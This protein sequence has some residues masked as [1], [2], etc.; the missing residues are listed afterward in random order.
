MN[1]NESHTPN[2]PSRFEAYRYSFLSVVTF[3]IIGNIL[4]IISVTRQSN[5]LKNNYYF[6]VLHLASSDL[7]WLVV[8][9]VM[10]INLNFA[11]KPFLASGSNLYCLINDVTYVF[12]FA[13]VCMMLIIS[14]LRYSA[15]VHPLKPAISRQKLKVVCG[16]GY[17]VGLVMGYG[18]GIP[19]C[20]VRKDNR[21][22][23]M[24]RYTFALLLYSA[25]VFFMG[26]VYFKICRSII[27]QN[28]D[29]KF[30][31]SNQSTRSSSSS[32]TGIMRFIRDRRTSLVCLCTVLCY[33]VGNI[34]VIAYFIMM[35]AGANDF[36]QKHIWTLHFAAVLRTVGSNSANPLIYGI[37][38]KK[39]LA[40]WRRSPRRKRKKQEN[41]SFE[42]ASE[43]NKTVL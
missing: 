22:Y 10:I 32:Y 37:F 5:L 28:R 17:T 25:P 9:F 39:L 27:K 30:L 19:E 38:D 18:T 1:L 3:G 21:P 23:W 29:I 43:E 11:E 6:L 35:L 41:E 12:E 34:P 40:F 8:T 33:G 24:S 4:V 31:R 20:F 16:F 13:A 14:V 2:A 42:I 26:V 7:G 15:T 36:L